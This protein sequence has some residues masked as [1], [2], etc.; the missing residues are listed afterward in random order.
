[1]S[2]PQ[3]PDS[4]AFSAPTGCAPITPHA[5]E[6]VAFLDWARAFFM[7][8]GLPFHAALIY[9]AGSDWL[10]NDAAQSH[11][12]TWFAATSQMFRMPGFFFIAGYF[13]ALMLA[14]RGVGSWVQDRARRLLIPLATGLIL[15][16]PAQL[17]LSALA[18]PEAAGFGAA[19]GATIARDPGRLLGHF[20]FLPTLML[21]CLALAAAWPALVRARAAMM[22]WAEKS[23]NARLLTLAIAVP[24]L[25][26]YAVID[27]QMTDA[28][29]GGDLG[30]GSITGLL[31]IPPLAAISYAPWF[32]LGV[33]AWLAP[34]LFAV[35]S[36]GNIWAPVLM[37]AAVPFLFHYLAPNPLENF[38]PGLT[39]RAAFALGAVMALLWLFRQIAGAGGPR[40][41]RLVDASLIIYLLHQPLVV[42]AGIML[43]PT[44]LPVAAKWGLAVVFALTVSLILDAV[45]RYSGWAHWLFHGKA[46]R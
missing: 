46:R 10:V 39:A 34:R 17:A 22:H 43:L 30:L 44:A 28:A 4:A 8:L 24:L 6:R 7:L 19:F 15:L 35:L 18:R 42:L 29:Q 21:L 25:G 36:Q 40:V 41:K 2:P 9:A 14:K 11:A 16:N 20:W 31:L 37:A 38:G 32:A 13:A 33:A 23:A 5:A 26:F 3:P 1:M 45:I 27:T 12:L